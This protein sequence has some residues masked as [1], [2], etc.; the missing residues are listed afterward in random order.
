MVQSALS[1]AE[2]SEL[3]ELN[4]MGTRMNLADFGDSDPIFVDTNILT[5]FAHNTE[6]FQASCAAFLY[7]IETG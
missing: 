4:L 6:P 2:L 5:Y 7:R 3:Y 1:V